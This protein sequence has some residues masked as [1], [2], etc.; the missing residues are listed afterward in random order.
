MFLNKADLVKF[1]DVRGANEKKAVYEITPS[2][3]NP[4]TGTMKDGGLVVNYCIDN[5]LASGTILYGQPKNI[6]LDLFSNYDVEVSSDFYFNK[7]MDAIRGDV[8]LGADVVAKDGI[9]KVT[10]TA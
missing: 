2:A 6:E 1:G 7:L 10:V 5:D 8:Q 3:Q 9:V 4:N